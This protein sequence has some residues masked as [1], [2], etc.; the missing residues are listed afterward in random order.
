MILQALFFLS[1]ALLTRA[2]LSKQPEDTIY[3]AKYLRFLRDQPHQ[4]F[5]FPH[6]FVTTLL[7]D[8]LG[9]QVELEVGNVMQNIGEIAI[10]SP[11]ASSLPLPE[12][13][14]PR[15]GCGSQ[16]NHW[17]ELSSICER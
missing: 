5:G 6:H 9:F 1:Y 8:A 3:A 16:I 13:F 4:A 7:V 14:C 12:Q 2:T 11:P 15:S 17:I 10:L